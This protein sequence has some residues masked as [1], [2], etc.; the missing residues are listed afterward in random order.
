MTYIKIKS[1]VQ[2]HYGELHKIQELPIQQSILMKNS[3]VTH[4]LILHTY[5]AYQATTTVSAGFDSGS[6]GAASDAQNSVF[7]PVLATV[8][9]TASRCT[10]P[11]TVTFWWSISM[12]NDSTPGDGSP[13]V[14]FNTKYYKFT[15]I[16]T[17]MYKIIPMIWE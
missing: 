8:W 3:I 6:A 17:R 11:T 2:E 10:L 15:I 1:K 4:V 16:A 14:K 5:I 7:F 12:S 9:K 13:Q